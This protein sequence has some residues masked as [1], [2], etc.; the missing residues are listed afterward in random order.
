[1]SIHSDHFHFSR[2]HE[3]PAL[4]LYMDQVVYI[5]NESVASF[6][7][8]SERVLTPSMVNNYV[9]QKLLPPPIKKK[10]NQDHLA[11]LIMVSTLK[12][13][14]PIADVAQLI[15]LLLTQSTMQ[16]CYNLFAQQ[17]EEMLTSAFSGKEALTVT[18]RAQEDATSALHAA[19]VSL[20]ARLLVEQALKPVSAEET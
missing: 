6:Y 18:L 19:L 12:G 11:F 1:M 16:E 3:L 2:W 15:Q 13:V 4:P 14:L 7:H 9:K 17:L 8:E 5:V 10:Y 20:V